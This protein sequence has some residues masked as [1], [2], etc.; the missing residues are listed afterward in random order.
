MDLVGGVSGLAQGDVSAPALAP[1]SDTESLVFSPGTPGG[2]LGL[3][4]SFKPAGAPAIALVKAGAVAVGSAGAVAPAFGQAT[5]SGN[6]LLA[7]VS[8]DTGEPATA[9]AGWLKAVDYA[10]GGMWVALWIKPNCGNGEAAPAFTGGGGN[11]P[12]IA[13]LAE[14]SGV[15]LA[16]PTEHTATAATSGTTLSLAAAAADAAFGDLVVICSRWLLSQSG[17]PSF[18]DTFNNGASAVSAGVGVG[19]SGGFPRAAN[20]AFAIIPPAQTSQ[21]LGVQPWAYDVDGFSAPAL[22]SQATVTLAA[23]PGKAYTV[24]AALFTLVSNGAGTTN[25]NPVLTDGAG[26]VF[27]PAMGV[28]AA[29][30]RTA[31]MQLTGLARKMTA[32]NAVT[33]KW[34]AGA[35]NVSESVYVAAYLR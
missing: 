1:D 28:E 17:S 35:A 25:N 23:T 10:A 4:A 34:V 16:V 15:A 9:Q 14:F 3:L 18:T 13:Q 33:C 24:T 30:N 2:N 5:A 22:G 31:V 21:P 26:I 8:S 29:T 12:M 19:A 7:W 11:G 27:E 32:G 20:H 6:F